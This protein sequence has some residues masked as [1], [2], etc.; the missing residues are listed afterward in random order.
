MLNRLAC[1]LRLPS[2]TKDY[3]RVLGMIVKVLEMSHYTLA[4]ATAGVYHVVFKVSIKS[5][6]SALALPMGA[7]ALNAPWL[8][9]ALNADRWWLVLIQCNAVFVSPSFGPINGDHNRARLSNRV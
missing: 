5:S 9:L 7:L 2:D 6:D 8:L 1:N 3:V 4:F